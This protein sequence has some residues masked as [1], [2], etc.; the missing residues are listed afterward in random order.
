M[1][2]KE[3][4]TTRCP[5]GRTIHRERK[6]QA[7]N[8]SAAEGMGVAQGRQAHEGIFHR[9]DGSAGDPAGAEGVDPGGD[10]GLCEARDQPR[11]ERRTIRH[12]RGIGGGLRVSPTFGLAKGHTKLAPKVV[13]SNTQVDVAV[14][15]G[16]GSKW[17]NGTVM[18]P[19]TRS[20]NARIEP[21]ARMIGE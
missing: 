18:I 19:H 13:I 8:R 6:S 20:R 2:P 5:A 1:L 12:P 14:R 9:K 17:M 7:L 4:R 21:C 10:C 11:I 16:I 3:G 15:T